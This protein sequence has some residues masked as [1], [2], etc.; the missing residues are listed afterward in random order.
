MFYYHPP[1]IDEI[2]FQAAEISIHSPFST[3]L[4]GF[5]WK[6]VF[7]VNKKQHDKVETPGE[8]KRVL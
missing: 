2:N 8:K 5:L 4:R 7:R 1:K 3:F 6:L